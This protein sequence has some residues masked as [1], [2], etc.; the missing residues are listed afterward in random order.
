MQGLRNTVAVAALLCLATTAHAELDRLTLKQGEARLKAAFE[1]NQVTVKIDMPASS[2]GVDVNVGAAQPFE[3]SEY[4]HRV[5]KHGISLRSGA[6][7]MV[8]K[9][10]VNPT[11][12]EFQLA[13]GGYGTFGDD[14]SPSIPVP[15]AE[16][17]RREKDLENWIRGEPN[18]EKKRQLQ[19]ELDDLRKARAREDAANQARVATATET[20]RAL[21][22]EKRL[23]GGS[24]FNVRYANGVPPE[25]LQPEALRAALAKWVDFRDAAPVPV[26]QNGL[27]PHG[28]PGGIGALRKGMTIDDVDGILGRPEKLETGTIDGMKKTTCVYQSG[29]GKVD[30]VFVEGVL[31]RW[32]FRS[33]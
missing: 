9:L 13:G 6:S 11:F 10:K 20:Q 21:I 14:D 1:G 24:R 32:A 7:V 31:V 2:Q 33:N 5:K 27:T 17:T 23:S 4:S 19:R 28:A 12:I 26:G 8:T 3:F 15:S 25:A 22:A 29:D 18:A 16:K 30:A